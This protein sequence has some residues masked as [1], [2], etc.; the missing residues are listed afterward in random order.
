M[1]DIHTYIHTYMH[2]YILYAYILYACIHTYYM[3][4]YI[5]IHMYIHTYIH[6]ICMQTAPT[7]QKGGWVVCW[8]RAPLCGPRDKVGGFIHVNPESIKADILMEG[9][10]LSAPVCPNSRMCEV[11]EGGVPRPHL[12]DNNTLNSHVTVMCQ[13]CDRHVTVMWRSCARHV[14]LMCQSCDSHVALIWQACDCDVKVMWQSCDYY[15]GQH[16]KNCS[17]CLPVPRWDDH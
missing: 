16:F 1:Y 2:I 15:D 5:H 13:S 10:Q 4:T 14:A 7:R 3:H 9:G 11:R 8:L 17:Q 6:T 12:E